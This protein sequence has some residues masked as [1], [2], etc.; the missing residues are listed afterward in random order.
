MEPG[1]WIPA[2][3]HDTLEHEQYVLEGEMALTLDGEEQLVGVGDAVY[4]PAGVVHSYENRGTIPVR[5]LCMVPKAEYRTDW[6][7]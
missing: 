3:S 4:I 2:H 6:A 5:F 7:E 1:E